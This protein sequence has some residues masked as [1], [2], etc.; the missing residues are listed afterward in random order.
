MD[1]QSLLAR[2]PSILGGGPTE[3]SPAFGSPR[4]TRQL[5]IEKSFESKLKAAL[6]DTNTTMVQSDEAIRQFASGENTD[7]HGT[8]IAVE[9]A[10][11]AFRLTL[12]VRNKA[13]E[14]YQEMMRMQV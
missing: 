2:S 4:P 14:A 9:K 10:G 8:M 7:L 11:L 5:E 6:S 13:L 12:Q 1:I 3:L